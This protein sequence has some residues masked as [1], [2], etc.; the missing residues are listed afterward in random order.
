MGWFQTLTQITR[1]PQ[2]P[3]YDYDLALAEAEAESECWEPD[4]VILLTDD[5]IAQLRAILDHSVLSSSS[6]DTNPAGVDDSPPRASAP[7]GLQE[8]EALRKIVTTRYAEAREVSNGAAPRSTQWSFWAGRA[9]AFSEVLGRLD[10]LI[11]GSAEGA[12]QLW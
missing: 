9:T 1:P 11:E 2:V 12:P 3:A 6:G 5:Q 8:L 7:A 4:P 10:R